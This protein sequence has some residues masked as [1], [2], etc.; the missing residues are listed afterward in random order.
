MSNLKSIEESVVEGDVKKVEELTKGAMADGVRA[1][2]ILD[3]G[4]IAGLEII[5]DLFERKEVFVPE[6][7]L[8]A[9]AMRAGMEL[10]EPLLAISGVEPIGK[11]VLGTVRGDIH[12]IGPKLLET[13]LNN[14]RI[15]QKTG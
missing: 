13:I 9:R 14:I 7:L 2:T 15:G 1:T 11:V 4:L 3:D 5:G 6:L 8:A 10:L 12:N